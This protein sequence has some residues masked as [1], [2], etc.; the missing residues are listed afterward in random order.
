[1]RKAKR[2][3]KNIAYKNIICLSHP[4]YRLA[5]HKRAKFH[6]T[7]TKSIKSILQMNLIF[8]LMHRWKRYIN[9]IQSSYR[10]YKKVQHERIKTLMSICDKYSIQNDKIWKDFP[11]KF[12]AGLIKKFLVKV[13]FEHSKKACK[14]FYD[15][16]CAN[17]SFGRNY[18]IMG[19]AIMSDLMGRGVR[20]F[21]LKKPD[22]KLFLLKN[23][24]NSF[25][26]SCD[27]GP[28]R[29]VVSRK[30][31]RPKRGKKKDQV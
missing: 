17:K 8:L 25:V 26:D 1:M 19:G 27:K 7:V 22:F 24:I 3:R 20:I 16:D 29:I 10:S 21:Q 14:Y 18:S 23:E 15:I 28:E 6:K 30:A 2:V 4:F 12:K 31:K 5:L 9:L 11:D 13:L